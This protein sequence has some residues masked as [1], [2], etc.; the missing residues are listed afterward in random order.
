MLTL[1]QIKPDFAMLLLVTT[2]LR[3]SKRSLTFYTINNAKLQAKPNL[4]HISHNKTDQIKL[5]M[6]C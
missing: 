6:S 2:S 1:A 3:D 4:C 5:I